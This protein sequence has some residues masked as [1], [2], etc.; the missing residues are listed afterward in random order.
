[1]K[2]RIKIKDDGETQT[3]IASTIAGYVTLCGLDGDDPEIG[4]FTV[5]YPSRGKINCL[6]CKQI[7]EEGRQWD[8]SDFE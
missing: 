3:H 2:R 4:Q 7:A 1:M 5:G 6:H 8:A